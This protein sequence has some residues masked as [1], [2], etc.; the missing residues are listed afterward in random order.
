MVRSLS[1]QNINTVSFDKK[2]QNSNIAKQNH[3]NTKLQNDSVCFT[4]NNNGYENP[5]SK[6]MEY[7]SASVGPV[8][9]SAFAGLG[10]AALT[11]KEGSKVFNLFKEP[12][13]R[14]K[15]GLLAA[16]VAL[17][18]TLP[19]ALYHRSVNA[20]A[21]QKEMDVFAREK[22]AETSLS[23]QIDAKARDNDIP[24]DDAIN[25]YTKFEIGRQGKAVG[26]V[27]T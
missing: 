11:E 4:S 8:I 1:G 9:M 14:N 6:P 10:A 19:V 5:V 7:F 21:K 2:C 15:I 22:S 20:F 18:L 12:I 16:G 17:A 23:E 3:L 26:I 27:N 24:L 13:S 25:S